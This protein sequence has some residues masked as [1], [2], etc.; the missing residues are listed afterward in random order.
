MRSTGP[1]LDVA[2]LAMPPLAGDWDAAARARTQART[3][4]KTPS[5]P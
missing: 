4:A 5:S 3:V 1:F 2:V